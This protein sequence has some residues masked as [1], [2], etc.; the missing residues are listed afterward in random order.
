MTVQCP[1]GCGHRIRVYTAAPHDQ[2]AEWIDGQWVRLDDHDARRHALCL[3][4][5]AGIPA[6]A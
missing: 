3:A 1:G 4:T 2:L 6:V 5:T